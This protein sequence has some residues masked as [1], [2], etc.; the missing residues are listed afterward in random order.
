MIH[1]FQQMASLSDSLFGGGLVDSTGLFG[2]PTGNSHPPKRQKHD[3]NKD[4]ASQQPKTPPKTPIQRWEERRKKYEPAQQD[5]SVPHMMGNFAVVRE[6][7]TRIPEDVFAEEVCSTVKTYG[8]AVVKNA[9]DPEILERLQERA[10]QQRADICNALESGGLT[11]NHDKNNT[12][13]HEVRFKEVVV[14]CKGRMDARY[15]YDN[16]KNQPATGPC[17]NFWADNPLLHKFIGMLLYGEEHTPKLVYAG[18]IFS[19]PGSDDQPWHQDGIPLFPG[20]GIAPNLPP[21]AI[22]VF[23][24]MRD[25]DG[26]LKAGPTEFVVGSHRMD[27]GQAMEATKNDRDDVAS[28]CIACPV[29]NQ[30]DMLVYDY[31]ICHRGTSNLTHVLERDEEMTNGEGRV[32]NILYLMYARPW[33]QEHMNFG[34]DELFDNTSGSQQTM[35]D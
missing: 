2:H 22:N 4:E 34:T 13:E 20:D 33:F 17:V 18:W 11:Y 27:V 32:R 23:I 16:E 28:P 9:I 5:E 8:V 25:Q 1:S 10:V 35:E 12:E 19:F 30:G 3:D 15:R 7:N 14:R 26:S 24:P 31:R 21:Y 29:L 6:R